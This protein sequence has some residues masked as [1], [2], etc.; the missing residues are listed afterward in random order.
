MRTPPYFS[1]VHSCLCIFIPSPPPVNAKTLLLLFQGL[2]LEP[3]VSDTSS[4]PQSTTQQNQHST[5]SSHPYSCIPIATYNVRVLRARKVPLTA[6]FR[7]VTFGLHSF[8]NRQNNALLDDLAGKV[9]ALRGVTV[10]IYD[11]AR[12]HD[13]IDSNVCSPPSVL[14]LAPLAAAHFVS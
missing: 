12:N 1:L 2:M 11:N 3:E 10:D 13:L 6:D 8:P 7:T 14:P 4:S 9:S 5:T